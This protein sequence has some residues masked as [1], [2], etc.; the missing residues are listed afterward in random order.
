MDKFVFIVAGFF[1]NAV[2]LF[3]LGKVIKNFNLL[4]WMCTHTPTWFGGTL[5]FLLLVGCAFPAGMLFTFGGTVYETIKY[6]DMNQLVQC[7]II[8]ILGMF[9]LHIATNKLK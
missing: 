9:Y 7:I 6:H 3:L 5:S 1:V 4:R 2:F 8:D